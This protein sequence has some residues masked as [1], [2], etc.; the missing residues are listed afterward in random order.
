MFLFLIFLIHKTFFFYKGAL[1]GLNNCKNST[2]LSLNKPTPDLDY[3]TQLLKDKKQLVAFP[4]VFT[5]IEKLLD[6][7]K[8]YYY[9]LFKKIFFL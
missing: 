5:H 2:N 9:Y 6:D 8:F 3:L 4:N 1:N 7:G